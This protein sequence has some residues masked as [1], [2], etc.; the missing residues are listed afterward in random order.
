MLSKNQIK[1]INSLQNKKFRLEYKSFIA[2]GDKIVKEA[3]DS[4][5]EIIAIFATS[6]W[7]SENK[8]LSIKN[9][10]V[11]ENDEIKKIS[12]LSTP[13]EVIAILKI[14]DK[15]LIE[16]EFENKF[17]IIL[18][19]IKDPGNLGTII[20]LADWF[21][22]ENIICSDDTVDA[23]NPKVVQASMG[24]VFRINIFYTD[25]GSFIQNYQNIENFNIYGAF[26]DGENIYSTSFNTRG[27]IVMGS[28]S[29]GISKHLEKLIPNRI[30]IPKSEKSCTESLNVAISTAIICSEIQRTMLGF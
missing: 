20:R 2:E 25:L 19:N 27:F 28:E 12:S 4:D 9:F 6:N 3:I 10:T 8:E 21:G 26:L 7:L 5:F 17:S 11:V 14:R 15:E 1:Y 23:Y 22:I 30:T 29:H 16:T 24:S 18:D 13:Q